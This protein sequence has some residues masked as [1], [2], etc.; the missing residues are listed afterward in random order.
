MNDGLTNIKQ[1]K[2]VNINRN[3]SRSACAHLII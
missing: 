2:T 3:Y 1:V